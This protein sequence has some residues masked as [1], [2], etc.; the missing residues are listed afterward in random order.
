MSQ[1]IVN[2][3]LIL[4]FV[5]I[6]TIVIGYVT[7]LITRNIKKKWDT[8]DVVSSPD[9]KDPEIAYQAPVPTRPILQNRTGI[10]VVPVMMICNQGDGSDVR[11]M[12]TNFGHRPIQVEGQIIHEGE[13]LIVFI[14]VRTDKPG[15]YYL[16]RDLAVLDDA[17]FEI[18]KSVIIRYKVRPNVPACDWSF[19]RFV[20]GK[21]EVTPVIRV[22][23]LGDGNILAQGSMILPGEEID[24]Y[25]PLGTAVD[26]NPEVLRTI[27]ISDERGNQVV[28]PVQI[29]LNKGVL[30]GYENR[31]EEA[32]FYYND[33]FLRDP[34]S[35]DLW[36]QRGKILQ[37]LGRA[38]EAHDS[39]LQALE[40][41]PASQ[42][43]RFA[44]SS[45]GPR[46]KNAEQLIQSREL[47]LI[48][49]HFRK[50]YTLSERI[51]TDRTGDFYVAERVSDRSLHMVKIVDSAYTGSIRLRRSAQ[52]WHS[53]HHP[54][55]LNLSGWNETIPYL[56]MDLPQG[57]VFGGQKIR[58]L[59]D[60]DL[61]ILPLSA[62]KITIGICKGLSY[63]HNQGIYHTFL[64]LTALFLDTDLNVRIGGFD[65]VSTFYELE[66]E[67]SC[68]I[69]A[70]EQLESDRYGSPGMKTDIYQAGSLLYYLLTGQHPYGG[71]LHEACS[72][73]KKWGDETSMFDLPTD[74]AGLVLFVPILS[75]A[76]AI[77]PKD[78]YDSINKMLRDLTSVEGKLEADL[79]NHQATIR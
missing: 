71:D 42:H 20:Q 17:G 8:K 48:P 39:Y 22:K 45:M 74:R 12:V 64:E 67:V 43:A 19:S 2:A 35:G 16:S 5:L 26:M 11:I 25:L 30:L 50:I 68:W 57:V 72:I 21:S 65:V 4:V 49:E 59:I 36:V 32:L 79:T 77:D 40:I 9:I 37:D 31:L 33:L 1:D 69:L 14:M 44:L 38:D 41:D 47:D 51:C 27:E 63:L 55:I 24:V 70:P 75:R 56:E 7:F 76:L 66:N 73:R 29:P 52:V 60:L 18:A 6:L 28:L 34:G 58:S 53:F 15:D 3:F 23:N 13:T 46:L 10:Y 78:R 62:V 61:P 54:N